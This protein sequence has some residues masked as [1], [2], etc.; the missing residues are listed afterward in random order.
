MRCWYVRWQISN[1]LDRGDLASYRTRGHAA[2]CPACQAF[3]A[4]LEALDGRLA[5]EAHLALAPVGAVGPRRARWPLWLGAPLAAAAAAIAIAIS[6]GE[7]PVVRE[8]DPTSA[9]QVSDAL[10]RVHRVAD[11][12]SQALARTPLEAELDNLIRD[13]KRGLDAVLD[14]GGLR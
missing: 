9:I 13:S 10:V 7:R 11:Q 3:A 1:A 6:P 8:V 12:V 2:R 5:R 4:S 14:A